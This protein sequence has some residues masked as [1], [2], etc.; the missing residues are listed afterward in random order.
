MYK[1]EYS[2]GEWINTRILNKPR[3]R[4]FFAKNPLALWEVKLINSL[5]GI[6]R[7]L[8]AADYGPFRDDGEIFNNEDK[9]RWFSITKSDYY[10]SAAAHA[11][12]APSGS[13]SRKTP[14]R[15]NQNRRP[16]N[17]LCAI[18]NMGLI[19]CSCRR[20]RWCKSRTTR[21]CVS[22]CTHTGAQMVRN[23][24]SPREMQPPKRLP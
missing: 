20:S 13:L 1:I 24:N 18:V 4:F 14:H 12:H 23:T 17:L 9:K 8:S 22:K 2:R 15:A 11:N 6:F 19:S 21:A 5:P 7:I 10:F 16:L 3:R